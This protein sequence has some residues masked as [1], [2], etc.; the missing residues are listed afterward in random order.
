MTEHESSLRWLA[1]RGRPVARPTPYI[2]ALLATRNAGTIRVLPWFLLFGVLAL[3]AGIAHAQLFGATASLPAYVVCFVAQLTMWRAARSR[4]RELA[5]HTSPW[6]GPPAKPLDGWFVASAVLAYG[7]G[8]ALAVSLLPAARA[9]G[10][11]TLLGVSALCAGAILTSF[12]RAPVLAEDEASFAVYRGLLAENLHA[13]SP[14]FAAVPPLLD[15]V[16][17]RL[18]PAYGPWLVAYVALVV[19]TELVAYVRGRRP[20]PPGR[21]GDPLPRGTAVDWSPPEPR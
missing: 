17:H 18:P 7:G 11:L 1:S 2:G 9:A 19:V 8:A 21:Y 4:Q 16:T 10:W 6:P 20:L 5:K 15:V 3:V 14:S 13:A 12:L